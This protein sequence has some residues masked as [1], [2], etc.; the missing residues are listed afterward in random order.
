MLLFTT[1]NKNAI[2]CQKLAKIADSRKSIIQPIR[3]RTYLN[4]AAPHIT[5]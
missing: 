5:S 1:K 4:A 3:K 2:F